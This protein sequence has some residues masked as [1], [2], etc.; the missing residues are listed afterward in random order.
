MVIP[1]A[2]HVHMNNGEKHIFASFGARDKSFEVMTNVWNAVIAAQAANQAECLS[3]CVNA[4]TAIGRDALLEPSIIEPQPLCSKLT[5]RELWIMVKSVYGNNLGLS[6]KEEI[7][8]Q[9]FS[10]LK[11]NN[12]SNISSSSSSSSNGSSSSNNNNNNENSFSHNTIAEVDE[13]KNKEY[14][15]KHDMNDRKNIDFEFIMLNEN[16]PIVDHNDGKFNSFQLLLF[17]N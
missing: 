3:N 12:T 2:I 9:G 14:H 1:N 7:E 11:I 16:T 5:D 8:M 6:A 10:P 15:V 17:L 4:E 13:E